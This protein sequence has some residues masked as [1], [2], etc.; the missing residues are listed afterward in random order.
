M[1]TKKSFG[2]LEDGREVF[3]YTLENASGVRADI[4]DFGAT[5][6]R[7]IAENAKGEEVDVVCGFD[8]VD[9]Y[10]NASGYQGAVIGRVCNRI[11][12]SKFTLNGVEYSLYANDGKNSAHGGKIGFNKR[13]WN[14]ISALD[15]DEP[16]LVL[17]YV[18]P[19]MEENY[20]GTLTTRVTYTLVKEGGLSM[21]YE[22]TCDRDTIINLTNHCYFN[23]AGCGN[24]TIKEQVMWIDADKINEQDYELIPTGNFINVEGTAYDFNTPK[25]IGRDFN[26]E[27]SMDIQHGGYD[28]NYIVNNYDGTVKL[29]ATLD[30]T[31]GGLRMSVYTNQPCVQ[32]YTSNMIDE[33]DI[34][35]KSGKPQKKNCAVCFETQHMPDAINHPNFTNT[36]LKPGEKYDF[37]TVYTFSKL[38]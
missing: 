25:P 29:I 24:G 10:L 26:S 4:S 19:D 20:P 17:E 22:A 28:N 6:V 7:L 5:V 33:N 9:G 21:R 12:N 15:G 27:P 37:T 14:V 18:S 36:V 31:A 30:E 34:P 35:F 23:L 32:V 1:I 8:S 2:F 13:V 11:H 3:T 16:A 38:S